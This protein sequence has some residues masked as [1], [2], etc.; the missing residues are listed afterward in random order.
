[1]MKNKLHGES[2]LGTP[3]KD[4]ERSLNRSLKRLQKEIKI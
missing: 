1:M 4:V 3:S 2:V